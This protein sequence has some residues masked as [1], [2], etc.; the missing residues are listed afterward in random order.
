[1]ENMLR[2]KLTSFIISFLFLLVSVAG[3]SSQ[4]MPPSVLPPS[5]EAAAII[6][7][8]QLS[9]SMHNGAANMAIPI[10]TM[11][12]GKFSLPISVN[13]STNGFKVDEIPSRLGMGWSLNAGGVITRVVQGK[14][15]DQATRRIKPHYYYSW[16]DSVSSFIDD[17]LPD[18]PDDAEPD[19]FRF[20]FCGYSGKF[21]IDDDGH[22]IQLPHSNLKIEVLSYYTTFRITATNGVIFTFGSTPIE[23]T[24]SHALA[25]SNQ[26]SSST[27]TSW[28]LNRIDMPDGNSIDFIYEAIS[29]ATKAGISHLIYASKTTDSQ[30]PIELPIQS[31]YLD[32]GGSH[33]ES[34]SSVNYNSFYLTGIAA[35]NGLS[36]TFD[37]ADRPDNGGD[38]RLTKVSLNLGAISKKFGFRYFDISGYDYLTVDHNSFFDY[39][40]RFFL[41]T[42][43]VSA[44]NSVDTQFYR[45]EY[46]NRDSL[47]PRLSYC[48]DHY[49]FYNGQLG[50]ENLLPSGYVGSWANDYALGNRTPNAHWAMKGLLSKATF[51][52]GGYEQFTYEA[53]TSDIGG[54]RVKNV[55]SFDPVTGKENGKYYT[56]DLM[57]TVSS[58]EYAEETYY[59]RRCT[60]G[61]LSSDN[62][63]QT[64]HSNSLVNLYFL[65][66]SHLA[67]GRVNESNSPDY[68]TGWIEHEFVTAGVISSSVV[69][70][71]AMKDIPNGYVNALDGFETKTSYYNKDEQLVKQV[72][73]YFH[74]VDPEKTYIS[75][76]ARRKYDWILVPT[77]SADR[78]DIMSYQYVSKWERLDSS[79]TREYD[80]STNAY[81]KAVTYNTYGAPDNVLPS[82]T[83]FYDSKGQLIKTTFKYPNDMSGAVYDTMISRNILEPVIE[84]KSYRDSVL[85]TSQKAIYSFF[86][87]YQPEI[88]EIQ[89]AKSSSSL[90][91]IAVISQYDEKSNVLEQQK[92]NDAKKSYIW[93]YEFTYPV[94]IVNN[95]DYASISFSSFE[96][97][98]KGNWDYSSSGMRSDSG[99]VT[100]KKAFKLGVSLNIE[101]TG[102]D[103]SKYY[104][105]TYWLKNN[106]DSVVINGGNGGTLL[107]TKNGWKLYQ[108]EIHSDSTVTI[109]GNGVIDELRLFPKNAQMSTFTYV[110]FVGA[111]TQCDANN[112]VTYYEYDEFGRLL[113]IRDHDKNIIKSLNYTYKETQ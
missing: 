8:G 62:Y 38:N 78:L 107:I 67:Y 12:V 81:S 2:C 31:S 96:A 95:A 37:Y 18:G 48:Q 74:A 58:P 27:M 1:M 15:D 51:P 72:R 88:S 47:P 41:D 33:T 84:Q 97:D 100:G 65:N 42:I 43:S 77:D 36:V 28:F 3:Q 34:V 53:N 110:P 91:A 4:I 55:I 61:N 19:E 68:S 109:S 46:I 5:P 45:F 108:K 21:I 85:L 82:E 87:G 23:A 22:V 98:S 93:D 64:L 102:L 35:S 9:V 56:Y 71:T 57:E 44:V 66:N 105:L 83:S 94:A 49:G 32:P 13:Y 76:K 63:R 92:A 69:R 59:K 106:G 86:N 40:K 79:E 60:A 101:R 39:N 20:N 80:V 90:E 70:G 54:I 50:N 25:G 26:F 99:F 16:N 11:K 30:C 29:I 113:R 6:K 7:E 103:T 89:S 104:A 52:T 73:N 112:R 75:L 111:L 14:P 17:I 10:Y 24:T